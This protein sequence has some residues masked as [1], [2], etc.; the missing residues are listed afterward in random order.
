[1]ILVKFKY[2]PSDFQYPIKDC[3]EKIYEAQINKSIM[4]EYYV[5]DMHLFLKQAILDRSIDPVTAKEMQDYF[6]GLVE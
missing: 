5:G 1:M 2:K 3:M 6:W 4:L